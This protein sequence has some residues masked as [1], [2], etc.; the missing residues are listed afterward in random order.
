MGKAKKSGVAIFMYCVIAVAAALAAVCFL[1][2]YC[3]IYSAG[4]ILWIGIIGFMIMYHLWLR[5]IMGNVSKLFK[6]NYRQRWFKERGFEKGLY[7]F[8][9]VKDWKDKTLTYNPHLF[10]L[11]DYTPEQIADTMAKAETDHWINEII[12]LSSILFTFVW[13]Q[14]WI[15]ALTAVLAM[16]FDGQ[17]IL[18]QRYNRP[19]VLRLIRRQIHKKEE[20]FI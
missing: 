9:K 3:K 17:F 18:I 19:R 20:C 1:L 5:L 14:G 13:G 8:L 2:Y 7:S 11:K 6:I 4:W 12:S 16:I 10:S 15:F